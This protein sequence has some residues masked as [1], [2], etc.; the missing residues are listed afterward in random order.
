MS[1]PSPR[2][3]LPRSSSVPAFL[4]LSCVGAFATAPAY[5]ADADKAAAPVTDAQQREEILVNGQRIH[6]EGPK[7]V[8]PLVNTPRSVIVLPKEVIEQTGSNSLADALR[9]VPGITF[10][11]AE[12]GNPIGDR[13]FIRGF[14]SQG[15]I[16]VDGVRD[17][18]SQTREV[19]AVDSVQIVRGSD[20][21]LG[22]RG[23]A[24]G[25][26]NILSR[27]P[28]LD[29]FGSLGAS[30]GEADYKRVTG[31]VNLKV[32]DTAAFRIE[33][34]WHD[35]DVAGRDAIWQ[36]RW[37]IAPSFA[38]GL[39][40][41]TRLTA[42]FY[43]MESEELPDSG[44][45]YLYTIANHPGTGN[46]TTQPALGTVTT[47]SGQTGYV[48]RK[49]FYGLAARDFRDATTNQATLRVEHDF[50]G[51]T[52]RNTAR[53]TH[54][55]QSFIFTLPDDSQ[56][57]VY[58]T[59]A[60]ATSGVN[61][62]TGG[63]KVT[64]GGYVWTRGNTRYGYSES[65]VD[66]TDLYGKFNTGGIEH[67]F[68]LGTE[69]SWEKTRRGTFVSANGSTISP[70]CD[71]VTIARSYCVSLFDPNPYAPWV[72]YTSDTSTTQTPIVK[73]APSTETQNDANT[74]AVYAFD[75][76]TLMPALILNLGARYDRFQSTVTLPGAQQTRIKRVDN[77]FNWQAGLVF[78]PTSETSLYASY[79]TAATPPNSLLGE[80]R[81]DNAISAAV[82][83]LLNPQK[84]KSYEVGAKASL[85]GEQLQLGAAVFQTE[86][87]NARVLDD[88]NTASFIGET[89]IRGIE[90]NVS[91][92]ILPGW[93]VF[94][95][96]THLDPKIIDGG[97]TTLTAAARP[98]IQPARTIGV[99]S[100]NTGKQVP[101]TAK[102]SFTA[103]TNI[104][105]TKRLQIGGTA[106]YMDEQIG[107]Y[108]D[109]RTA[110]QND[111]GVVSVNPATKVLTRSIPDYWRFDA[112]ASYKLTDTIDL[113]VNA[114]NL[115]NKTYFSQTFTSHYASIAAGRTV[116]GTV[117]LRF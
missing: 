34:M 16:Y 84:T 105:V 9:T 22:G 60:T 63:T 57:N 114:Q 36:K 4:A 11:A 37:G 113:S 1:L 39:G 101:Q 83:N 49:T 70:R 45:P 80:G 53:Y 71:T 96:F 54:S 69:I 12:G 88:T 27:L 33:G 3:S 30:Y 31:D 46:V 82:L 21:T 68:S 40:T 95:G 50:G 94:G 75:S 10:G 64:G 55:S 98:G 8:A 92:T 112:R 42:S 111:A 13:P 19:F 66:Q 74:K 5:A 25:T 99:V 86:I 56:G 43:H 91:G 110:T 107:G 117:N 78:K 28:Q 20:S 44:I 87:S 26:I 103:T 76:I 85:F 61:P 79:A 89:R 47:A 73:G 100:V 108:A 65:I 29:T 18:A 24:G 90:F 51:I 41:P 17:L 2:A 97:F 67:S 102:N 116:F 72:N 32:S 52:L 115:T 104:D 23:S 59:T 77:L 48:S 7:Q 38:V 106:L 109:N 93:T 6:D 14:D 15:S 58:G 62:I 81:E 35:Q